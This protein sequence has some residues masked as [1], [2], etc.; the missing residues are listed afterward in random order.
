MAKPA[1]KKPHSRLNLNLLYP[2]GSTPK[3]PIRF[4]KWLISYG[5]YIVVVVEI[6]VLTCFAMRFRLDAELSDLKDKINSQVPYLESLTVDD[7]LIGQTQQR[8]TH[9]QQVYTTSPIWEK[10]LQEVTKVIPVGVK[11]DNLNLEKNPTTP[12]VNIKFVAQ[13]SSN[14]DVSLLIKGLKTSPLFKDVNLASIT[15]EQG[16]INFSVTCTTR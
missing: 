1:Q 9:I 11:L 6:G 8:L 12:N 15:F 10:V 14:N 5:R 2:S 3:L 16:V 4:I 7:T 13:T